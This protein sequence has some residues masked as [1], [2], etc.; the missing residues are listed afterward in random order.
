M[1]SVF[2][3]I[4]YATKVRMETIPGIPTVKI[5]KKPI[6]LQEDAIPL[7]IL[8]PGKEV[9]GMEAFP[10]VV[11]Y[12]YEV[13]ISIIRAGNRIY[14]TDVE[15]FLTLRQSI[16]NVLYQP[17]LPWASTVLDSIIETNP[18]FDIVSGE[19]FNYDISGMVIRYKSI[20]ERVS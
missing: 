14:E 9:V 10:N 1:P 3:D 20:E 5:R 2:W 8:T 16:R 6:L 18:A 17:V 15:Q 13:Q 4:L 19:S 12:I 11:E 7:I